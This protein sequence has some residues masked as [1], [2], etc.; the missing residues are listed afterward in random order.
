MPERAEERQR[1]TASAGAHATAGPEDIRE[2]RSE[3]SESIAPKDG[4]SGAPAGPRARL[5]GVHT[6]G[7]G[8]QPASPQRVHGGSSDEASYSTNTGGASRGP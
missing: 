4:Y 6:T 8:R 2:T 5:T 1:G 3:R 7:G